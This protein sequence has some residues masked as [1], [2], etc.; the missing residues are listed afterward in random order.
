MVGKTALCCRYCEDRFTESYDPTYETN[1]RKTIKH[2]GRDIDLMVTDT[3]GQDE[4]DLFRKEY[5]L[6]AHGYVLV[7]SVDSRRSLESCES[8]NEKLISL[9]GAKN[10][11]RVLVGNKTDI[12][13]KRVVSAREG[14][15]LGKKLGCKYIECSAK[16]GFGIEKVFYELLKAIDHPDG[17][18]YRDMVVWNPFQLFSVL[19]M[20]SSS[21]SIVLMVKVVV[22]ATLVLGLAS[23]CV[24][25]AIGMGRNVSGEGDLLA[26]V[27]FGFGLF[28]FLVS[29]MGGYGVLKRRKEFIRVYSGAIAVELVVEIVVGGYLIAEVKGLRDHFVAGLLCLLI[30]AILQLC[31]VLACCL[32]QDILV[33]DQ[34]SIYEPLTSPGLNLFPQ[35]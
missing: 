6:G 3:Q 13:R 10:V 8:L 1:Y 29:V 34:D 24:G 17:E 16:L 23:F 22:A 31:S 21:S 33:D 11:P 14:M 9:M 20:D 18:D 15:A 28:T 5:C 30:S 4:Q 19:R 35:L 7:F 12:E 26:Y 2:K 32:C 27:L 25:L